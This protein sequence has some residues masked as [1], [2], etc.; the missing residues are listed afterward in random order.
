M[1]K[2]KLKIGNKPT[3][4]KLFLISGC[5]LLFCLSA[6][7]QDFQADLLK[8]RSSLSARI[9]QY[10]PERYNY[11]IGMESVELS[12]ENVTLN[13]KGTTWQIT[14]Q[15]K[16]LEKAGKYEVTVFFNCLSY[17]IKNASVS[18]D[19]NFSDWSKENYVLMPAA[20]YNGNRYPA[21][22]ADYMPF[23]NEFYQLGLDKPILLSD[24]PRLNY[25][26]GVSRVQERS[27]S[28]SI[29]SLGFRSEKEKSGFFLCFGQ[30]GDYGDYG[31]DI[32]E[33]KARDRVTITLTSPVVREVRRHWL[34]RMDAIPS[35]D[36]TA[37]FKA[38]D[39]TEIKFIVDFFPCPKVQG[40]FDELADI[41]TKNYPSVEKPDLIPFSQVYQIQEKKFN[42]ENWRE[43]GY[44]AGG[45]SNDFFQDWQIG[46]TGGMISTLPLLAEGTPQ[47]KERVLM[48]FD[49]LFAKGISPSGYYYGT[50]YKEKPQGDFPNKP[51]GKDL[52]L[53]RKNADATWYIFKQFDLMQKMNIPVK[54]EWKKGNLNAVD[55][56][57]K[58]WE[59][60]GQLGQFVNEQTG[61]LVIGNTTSA[62]IFPA[63]LCAAYKQTGDQK[64]LK[65]AEIIGEYYYQNFISKGLSCGGPGDAMQSFDS[66]SSYGLLEAMVE[67]YETTLDKKWL[68]RSE[69]MGRQFASW[70]VAF[71]FKF[72]PNT[73]HG[74]LDIR[75]TG[76]VYANTQNK[77]APGGICTHSGLALLKLY[78]ATNDVFYINLLCDIAHAIPQFMSWKEH[79]QPGFHEGWISER[80]N[81]NDWLEGIGGTMAYSCWAETS[82]L[83]TS[84]ELP[85]VYV[86]LNTKQVFC[87]DH[88]SASIIKSKNGK[89]SLSLTN[90][91]IYDAKV[92]LLAE[93]K[94]QEQKPLGLNAFLNWPK[95]DVP[96]GKTVVVE[97]E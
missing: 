1:K 14:S 36:P 24:Q 94:D 9:N 78:R 57:I 29:P 20:V 43:A 63:S 72:P 83:L 15:V 48:N 91:N 41:R 40:L 67:L 74:K 19:L 28:M 51:L 71:D 52:L 97:L 8:N 66:E 18:V 68:T 53:V 32:E 50:L 13:F 60:Y 65:T 70:I 38:G 81:L 37:N 5:I 39:K 30:A 82:M 56:Q 61:E 31:I 4:S 21:I 79:P 34:A 59:K 85:G 25:K 77:T 33:N 75:S 23:F 55:A 6:K 35:T 62:G 49:W 26:D 73:A 10:D 64:Y 27:G 86:N 88:I 16:P 69:E 58:T 11:L 12:S 96:A 3:K 2:P 44:Y 42:S 46:W 45:V 17:E 93:S 84:V 92:K 47:T 89:V 76:G 95:I 80:C 87:L 90:T 54:V 22:V 7:A